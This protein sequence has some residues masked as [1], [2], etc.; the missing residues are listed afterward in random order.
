MLKTKI[1]PLALVIA[2]ISAPAS[3]DLIISEYIEGSSN[4]A[5]ELYNNADTEIS[6]EG[7]VLGLYSNGSS[8]IGNSI[9]LTGTLA[10]NTTYIISNPG[11]TADILDIADT[12]STVTYY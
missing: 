11:A 8:S 4:K 5:I 2:S 7:Y 6:L 1:T 12:T 10:A 3:A 9:D